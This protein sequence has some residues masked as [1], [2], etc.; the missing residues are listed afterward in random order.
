[1]INSLNLPEEENKQV[2][3]EAISMIQ[4]Y[5]ERLDPVERDRI[6]KLEIFDEFEEWNML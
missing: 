4:V 6:N 5:Q 1:M 2:F 3:V